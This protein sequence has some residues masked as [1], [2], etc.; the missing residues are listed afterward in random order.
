MSYCVITPRC[1][2]IVRLSGGTPLVEICLPKTC[3]ACQY[4]SFSNGGGAQN[5]RGA[6]FGAQGIVYLAGEAL[7]VLDQNLTSVPGRPFVIYPSNS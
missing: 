6:C 1:P 3:G 5:W 2:R 7:T 4:C